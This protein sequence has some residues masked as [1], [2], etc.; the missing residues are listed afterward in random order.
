MRLVA[1][2]SS[3][4]A[5]DSE[6]ETIH[7]P[8]HQAELLHALSRGINPAMPPEIGRAHAIRLLLDHI[9]K[10]E[11]DLTQASSEV[12]LAGLATPAMTRR[13]PRRRR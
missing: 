11:I 5:E 2:G 12:E 3:E 4:A 7:L 8:H 9:E 1:G 6:V 13:R 10:T